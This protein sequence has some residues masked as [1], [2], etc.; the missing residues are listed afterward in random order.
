MPTPHNTAQ[1]GD[2]ANVVLMPG[3]PL[4]AQFVAEHFLDDVVQFNDVRN[5]LGF[6]GFYEGERVS[7]MGSGMGVP[8]MAI[9][10][11]ELYTHYDVDAIIRIG[12]TGGLGP[13]IGVRDII[14]AQGACTDSNYLTRFSFPGTY[15]PIADFG[16]LRSAVE[17][18]ERHGLTHHVGNIM[19]TDVFY[20]ETSSLEA[21]ARMGVLGVE[22]EAAV[23]YFNAAKAGKRA[24]AIM[25][26][27]DLPIT[28][29]SLDSHERQ[30]S[31]TEMM[32]VALDVA[33][34]C[35]KRTC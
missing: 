7:V 20:S 25:T 3:D 30:V 28:G 6:T 17:S 2:I 24:L 35:K 5:M 21:L 19:T 11:W 33:L 34:G 15:A 26:V 9:Y 16:L 13:G 8:S 29:E 31:F 27:S 14:L 18:C 4:R 22:M 12:S 23:L 1:K 32:Q 10:S